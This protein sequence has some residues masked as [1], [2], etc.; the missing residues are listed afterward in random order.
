MNTCNIEKNGSERSP[1]ADAFGCTFCLAPSFCLRMASE[2]SNLFQLASK[3]AGLALI[4]RSDVQP[5]RALAELV[6]AEAKLTSEALIGADALLGIDAQ[7]HCIAGPVSFPRN[8]DG[9]IQ[10]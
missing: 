10:A 5:S 9:H 3:T 6:R 2:D 7:R 1:A 4:V 8:P